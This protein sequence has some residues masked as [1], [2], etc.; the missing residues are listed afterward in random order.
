MTNPATTLADC[1]PKNPDD[2]GPIAVPS[3]AVRG[4][5][6]AANVGLK[7]VARATPFERLTEA[8]RA[9]LDDTSI[10]VPMQPTDL[11]EDGGA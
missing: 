3:D 7:A 9:L 4:V 5:L 1:L 6:A 8:Q 10:M 11:A 2:H